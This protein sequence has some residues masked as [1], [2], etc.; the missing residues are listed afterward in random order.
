MILSETHN[1]RNERF[2]EALRT[3]IGPGSFGSNTTS[4]INND[5]NIEQHGC[6]TQSLYTSK[7]IVSL[8]G[9][10]SDLNE[11]SVVINTEVRYDTNKQNSPRHIDLTSAS[12]EEEKDEESVYP[13]LS[14]LHPQDVLIIGMDINKV[15]RCTHQSSNVRYA[16]I[17]FSMYSFLTSL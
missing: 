12:K 7:A 15:I 10:N 13:I 17:H 14:P 5:S 3:H 2:Q 11:T 1:R 6:V 4:T 9:M 8:E 16:L